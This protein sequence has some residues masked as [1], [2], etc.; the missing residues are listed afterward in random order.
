[1]FSSAELRRRLAAARLYL[2]F[3][4]ERI[5][6]RDPLAALE[7]ALPWVDLVQVRP[8]PADR[9]LDPQRSDSR[10]LA[11]TSARASF[12]WSVRVLDL[13]A[14][15]GEA[16]PLVL[17]NDRVDVAKCLLERGLAGVH[18]G[19]NDTPPHVAREVLG[20]DALIGLSTHSN[21]QVA[22]AFDAPIDYLGFGPIRATSTKGYTKGLGADAAWIAQQVTALPVFPIGG[23]GV[24]EVEELAELG[25]AAVSSAI[26][27]STDPAGAARLMRDL[28]AR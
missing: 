2:I 23:I 9:D 27:E 10:A 15:L 19:Q 22:A 8:K 1:M 17:A 13:A 25:R 14:Q 6:T 18:V 24:L 26:L 28:L 5:T 20:A 7:A 3:T 11:T 12:D 4:P 16:R 21:A